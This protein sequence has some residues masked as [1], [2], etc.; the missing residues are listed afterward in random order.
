MKCCDLACFACS[1][2][3]HGGKAEKCDSEN[4]TTVVRVLS[5]SIT[6]DAT[7]PQYPYSA[8]VLQFSIEYTTKVGQQPKPRDRG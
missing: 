4:S 1:V 5:V 2:H 3:I 8:Q 7:L 6:A